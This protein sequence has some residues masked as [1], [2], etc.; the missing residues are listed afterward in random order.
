MRQGLRHLFGPV[1]ASRTRGKGREA[2]N[3][4]MQR[5]TG[6]PSKGNGPTGQ[7][8]QGNGGNGGGPGAGRGR[9]VQC[10]PPRTCSHSLTRSA[11]V[12]AAVFSR[13]SRSV[14]VRYLIEKQGGTGDSA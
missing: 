10:L 4:R 12:T 9:A 8:G 11:I 2:V 13:Q 14:L 6:H 3:E 5:R 7:R 1:T